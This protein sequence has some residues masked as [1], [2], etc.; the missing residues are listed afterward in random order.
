VS[1]D[2][3]PLPFPAVLTVQG[4]SDEEWRA[5]QTSVHGI[6]DPE[7]RRVCMQSN[8]DRAARGLLAP[9]NGPVPDHLV[10]RDRSGNMS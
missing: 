4:I 9:A 6:A 8:D 1:F 2:R 7:M 10:I 5:K 3:G